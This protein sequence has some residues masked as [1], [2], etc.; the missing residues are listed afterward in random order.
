ML[1]TVVLMA[2]RGTRFSDLNPSRPKPL[3]HLHGRPL[4]Q[5]VVENLRSTSPQKYIFVCQSAHVKEFKLK[6]VFESFGI[7]FEIAEINEVTQ[8]AACSALFAG[9]YITEGEIVFANSDQYMDFSMDKFIEDCNTRKLDGS[10]VTMRASG[11]KWSY[12][13]AGPDNLVLEVKEKVAISDIATT[14]VYYYR[15]WDLFQTAAEEMISRNDSYNNEFY[16][17]PVYNYLLST[18]K[19]SH[20][21]IGENEKEMVG[22]GTK[23]DFLHFEAEERSRKISERLF[24]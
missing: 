9:D 7:E 1:N 21:L 2:G 23:E 16:L 8:G 13:K 17:A 14:G 12:I 22:L 5:W 15:N 18:H 3:V 20:Y 4:V 11:S 19:V 24:G 6:S 10:L